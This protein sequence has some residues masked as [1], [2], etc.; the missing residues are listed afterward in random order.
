M[1]IV[2]QVNVKKRLVYGSIA[3][4]W[5]ILPA[6]VTTMGVLSTDIIKGT[7]IPWG[8]YSSFAAEKAITSSIFFI[9]LLLPL[10]S[11]VFCYSRIVYE[12]KHKVTITLWPVVSNSGFSLI[13]AVSG[14]RYLFPSEINWRRQLWGV[15]VC[16]PTTF[17]SL[18]ATYRRF[19]LPR[20]GNTRN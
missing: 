6:F 11:M 5:I 4:I 13:Y 10:T 9:A 12:L 2:L 17:N 16:S 18:F 20:R 19:F 7:C 8:I 3:A 1:L 14:Y 15:G